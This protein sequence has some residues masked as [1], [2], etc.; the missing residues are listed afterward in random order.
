MKSAKLFIFAYV[1]LAL[2]LLVLILSL[3]KLYTADDSNIQQAFA[4]FKLKFRKNYLS[5]SENTLRFHIFAENYNLITEHNQ[6]PN[7]SFK[8]SINKFADLTEEEFKTMYTGLSINTNLHSEHIPKMASLNDDIIDWTQN[9]VPPKDHADLVG[10]L[11][12][13][14]L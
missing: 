4:D 12:L 11:V 14:E 9:L 10:P 2:S 5:N 3:D 7:Q 13:L 1:T 6:K 8:H